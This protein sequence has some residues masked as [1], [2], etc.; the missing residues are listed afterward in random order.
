MA[1]PTYDELLDALTSV[2]NNYDDTGCE[3]CGVIDE[4]IV[5]RAKRLVEACLVSKGDATVTTYEGT[6]G[7]ECET[8]N[9]DV[10]ECHRCFPRKDCPHHAKCKEFTTS[11][12]AFSDDEVKA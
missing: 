7:I 10:T 2:V 5:R 6:L 4:N 11:G 9:C 1:K 12:D 8:N 3:S